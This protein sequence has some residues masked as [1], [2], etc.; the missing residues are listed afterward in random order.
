MMSGEEAAGDG[1]E[2]EVTRGEGGEAREGDAGA[3]R[4][5]AGGETK[6]ERGERKGERAA[7]T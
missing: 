1:S 7:R 4:R 5:P 6:R 3:Q 2:L